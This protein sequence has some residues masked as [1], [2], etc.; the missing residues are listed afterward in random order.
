MWLWES[1]PS[2]FLRLLNVDDNSRLH[3]VLD[4]A[5]ASKALGTQLRAESAV[6]AGGREFAGFVQEMGGMR[7][8][9]G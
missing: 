4:E 9:E 5:K 8:K 1:S 2:L 7:E 6:G 3:T